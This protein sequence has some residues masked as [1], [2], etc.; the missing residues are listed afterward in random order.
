MKLLITT[1]FLAIISFT[2]IYSQNLLDDLLSNDDITWI[3]ETETYFTLEME[4]TKKK[5]TSEFQN[6]GIQTELDVIKISLDIFTKEGLSY[7]GNYD[8]L[9][10][11]IFTGIEKKEV[12]TTDSG[13]GILSYPDAMNQF[14]TID[15]FISFDAIT[16]EETIKVAY[17][18]DDIING[19]I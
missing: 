6:S 10:E 5:Y 3:A 12:L 15:S 19:Y 16:Y 2:S 13:E 14:T 9:T 8:T 4:Q 1:F 7:V 11:L 18:E 17:N